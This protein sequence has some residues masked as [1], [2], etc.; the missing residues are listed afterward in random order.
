MC[1][2]IRIWALREE[3]EFC[4]LGPKGNLWSAVLGAQLCA[5]VTDCEG[6]V[7]QPKLVIHRFYRVSSTGCPAYSDQIK[8]IESRAGA[9]KGRCQVGQKSEFPDSLRGYS[10]SRFDCFMGKH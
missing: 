6:A 1:L 8:R 10:E 5:I 7:Q 3:K 4:I 9:P 2:E